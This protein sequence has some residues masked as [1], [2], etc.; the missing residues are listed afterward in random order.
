VIA[1]RPLADLAEDAGLT[2]A[3]L[4]T[5]AG[6]D[7]AIVRRLWL[8]DDWLDGLHATSLVALV[9]VLPGLLEHIGTVAVGQRLETVTADLAD[10]GLTVNQEA[11][12]DAIAGGVDDTH[13]GTALQSAALIVQGDPTAAGHLARSFGRDQDHALGLVFDRLL[14]NPEPLLDAAAG[15]VDQLRCRRSTGHTFMAGAAL[16]HHLARA[17]R[18]IDHQP[19]TNANQAAFLRRSTAIGLVLASDDTDIVD[20][21]ASDVDRSSVAARV[22]LWSMAAYVRDVRPGADFWVPRNVVL[23]NTATEVIRELADY[24]D[25]YC[26]YL[27]AVFLPRALALDPTFG[28][29]R[30]ALTAALRD[31][32]ERLDDSQHIDTLIRTLERTT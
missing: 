5:F 3:D 2:A 8:R 22:E 15:M 28:G 26:A 11:V 24:N 1:V 23:R 17:G 13:I 6:L 16:R 30:D 12:T 32:R 25:A 10:H 29:Q 19:P 21:Y 7:G 20:A 31:R 4:A 27:A 18:R 9:G 14:D